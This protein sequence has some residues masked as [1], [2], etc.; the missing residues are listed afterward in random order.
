[1]SFSAAARPRPASR[2]G[3]R[4]P[5]GESPEGFVPSRNDARAIVIGPA[6]DAPASKPAPAPLAPAAKPAPAPLAPAATPAASSAS[7]PTSKIRSFSTPRVGA[8][9]VRRHRGGG[10]RVLLV[11][12]L[13]LAALAAG[14]YALYYYD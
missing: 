1:G 7:V 12:V 8:A 13:A 6:V 4:D 10:G 3:A 14:A 9:M 11:A 5:L 2:A